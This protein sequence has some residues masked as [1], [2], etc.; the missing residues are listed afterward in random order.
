MLGIV[1][2]I[3]SKMTVVKFIFKPKSGIFVSR[4]MN[5]M[6]SLKITIHA[7][8]VEAVSGKPLVGGN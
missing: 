4:L 2:L 3:S 7:L 1:D 8:Q 5:H 6:H